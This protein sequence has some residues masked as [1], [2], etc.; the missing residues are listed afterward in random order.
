MKFIEYSFSMTA[1]KGIFE[2][3]KNENENKTIN[4][5]EILLSNQT[6]FELLSD[7]TVKKAAVFDFKSENDENFKETSCELPSKTYY[8]NVNEE[9][10]KDYVK[11]FKAEW[12][13]H[14]FK[15]I[16]FSPYVSDE[17]FMDHLMK[18]YNELIYAQHLINNTLKIHHKKTKILGLD[19]S[20]IL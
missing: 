12:K 13:N 14:Y 5:S 19:K 7:A 18:T 8:A 11:I 9:P 10:S 3:T 1:T 16:I 15:G 4:K 6:Y 20:E 2:T 17:I